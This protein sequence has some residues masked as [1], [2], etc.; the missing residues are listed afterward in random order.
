MTKISVFKRGIAWL[1]MALTCVAAFGLTTFTGTQTAEAAGSKGVIFINPGHSPSSKTSGTSGTNPDGSVITEDYMNEWS[2]HL[3]GKK[4]QS[5]GYTVYL[6]NIM[7]YSSDL[8]V[9][10]TTP[11]ASNNDYGGR[12]YQ[13]RDNPENGTK[14]E[15]IPACNNPSSVNPSVTVK[16]DLIITMHRNSVEGNSTSNGLLVGY[17][18]HTGDGRSS[19]IVTRSKYA[20]DQISAQ[21]STN[22]KSYFKSSNSVTWIS[23]SIIKYSLAPSII[24]EAGFMTNASD[25]ANMQKTACQTALMDSIAN[26]VES[27][28]AK[29][30][31]SNTNIAGIYYNADTTTA[32]TSFDVS[33]VINGSAAGAEMVIWNTNYD[34]ATTGY[35]YKATK[36]SDGGWHVTFDQKKHGGLPGKYSI[37]VYA[38]DA[39]G[40]R[41][42]SD[43]KYVTTTTDLTKPTTKGIYYDADSTTAKTKFDISAVV[44]AGVDRDISKVEITVWNTDVGRSQTSY[45]YSGQKLSDGGWHATFDVSKHGGKSGKYSIEVYVTDNK[46]VRH[47]TTYKYVTLQISEPTG[48][49]YYDAA[50]TTDKTKFDISAVVKPGSSDISKVEIEVWN[51]SVGK[52]QTSY[53]YAGQKLSDG[54]WHATFDA[55]KHGGKGGT[56][57]IKVYATDSEGIRYEVAEKNVTVNIAKPTTTGIYYDADNTTNKTQFDISAVVKA[58]SNDIS[59][60]EITVWNT[61]VG[62]SQT[63]YTY[64]GQKLS[65]G[66]WHATF[67]AYKH[68]GK[69]GKYSIEVYVTDSKGVRYD[70]IYKYVTVNIIPPTAAI[71]YDTASTTTKTKFD[72]STV[73][74]PG[75]NTI[76]KVDIEVWNASVGQSQTSYTYAGQK[77]SDGG[78]H[79]TFDVSKHGGKGGTYT[80]KTY[81]TDSKGVRYELAQKDVAVTITKPTLS[82]IYYDANS[83][84][85]KTSFDISAVVKK[86]TFDIS[87][88]EITVWN[89]NVGRSQTSYTYTGQKLS[90]GG[91]HATF[92]VNKHGGQ[93]GQYSIEVYVTDSAGARYDTSF[94]YVNV[95]TG[96]TPIMG[97]SEATVAQMVNFYNASKKTYPTYYTQRG[98]NLQQFAQL[99]YDVCKTEGVR[100]EVAW[101]QMC[102]E[103]GYL[104]FGGDVKIGQFNFAGLGA[105]GGGVP[106]FDF[107]AVYGDNANGIKHGIIG[108]VQHLKCYACSDAVVYKDSAGKPIDPRWADYLR[109]KSPSVEGLSGTWAASGT[110]G[111]DIVDMMDRILAQAKTMTASSTM[112][113]LEEME[114]VPAPSNE[115]VNTPDMDEA[116]PSATPAPETTEEP[117]EETEPDYAI[118]RQGEEIGA[119]EEQLVNYYIEN[120][121]GLPMEV[122]DKA[123]NILPVDAQTGFPQYYGMSLE[124]FVRLYMEEA[125]AEGVNPEVAFAQAMIDTDFLRFDNGNDLAIENYV[126]SAEDVSVEKPGGII[127]YA[128]VR[129]GIRAQIQHLKCYASMDDCV[130]TVVDLQWQE[131]IRGT[132][133][134]AALLGGGVWY[135]DAGYG[136]KLVDAIKKILEQP[137]QIRYL[138]VQPEERKMPSEPTPEQQQNE[139][140]TE[141]QEL[142]EPDATQ[143][144]TPAE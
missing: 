23:N 133:K 89:T 123:G 95:K 86:G 113:V 126:F 33:A 87:K 107:S 72:I 104:Q 24:I 128:T 78:W 74:T 115:A 69:G 46:G 129:E 6:T 119:V 16:P 125:R 79:A 48:T 130:R 5:L 76:S 12:Q 59:K 99:Y 3:L 2:S 85:N 140:N 49:I 131:D 61:D 58:G 26:G 110:Y 70:T 15:L 17:S 14:G 73:V 22:M 141:Q 118:M 34:R 56:Y 43:Y 31:T 138:E 97:T 134:D 80:I 66:G 25:L 83:T 67:D 121:K 64:S 65:D 108:H 75:S 82:G 32:K 40:N 68:G 1:L 27:F 100:A 63:S 19:D 94:K 4:L 135:Q 137:G 55:Y 116:A 52:A 62:R 144:E 102:L 122:R 20:S 9:I 47:A 37:E 132:I 117:I 84:T 7:T 139:E 127:S 21:F 114:P 39:K 143:T 50:S 103:T 44:E 54:G 105:T 120:V 81:V 28:F 124:E 8:P 91:W 60:V 136:E 98:V 51:A 106:G 112:D 142:A 13:F 42:A 111:Q 11:P 41:V 10:I 57:T 77:L 90:D 30:P 45:T 71:Y 53:T 101:A 29:Y 88:V 92:D 35:T 38:L 18:T 36:L 109:G 96:V 93:S